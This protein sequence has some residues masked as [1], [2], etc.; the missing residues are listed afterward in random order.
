MCGG[1]AILDF[2]GDG[3]PDLFFTNGAKL[4]ELRK[5]DASFYS[6]LLHNRGDGT[7]DD[8]TARAGLEGRD[9]DF[10][11]GV[12]AGDYDNDGLTGPLPLPGRQERAL[13][14]QRRRHA[15]A[16][17][18]S[19]RASPRRKTCSR[20]AP[21]GSTTTTTAGST[22][23]SRTTRYWEPCGRPRLPPRGPGRGL[24]PADPLR[25]RRSPLYRNLGDGRFEDVSER[26]GFA[27][28]RNG[29]GMGIAVADFNEDGLMD[30]FVANDTE[31]NFLFLN[32]GDGTFAQEA[33]AWNVDYNDQGTRSRAWERTPRTTTT[34]APSTSSATAW[35]AGLGALPQRGRQALRLRLARARGC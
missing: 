15:S 4:P 32:R 18:A 6:C 3:L 21:P 8:V 14:Q 26:S 1:V 25:E 35:R 16:T 9:L 10:S 23:W 13:P 24:L 19:A 5:V 17:S 12:A 11:F 34:T 31:P 27:A 22:S 2:D 28:A 7:F 29:K 30:V 20:C 33:A